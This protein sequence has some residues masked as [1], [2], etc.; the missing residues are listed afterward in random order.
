[1]GILVSTY[2]EPEYSETFWNILDH[3]GSNLL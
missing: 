2:E 1:M 3:S